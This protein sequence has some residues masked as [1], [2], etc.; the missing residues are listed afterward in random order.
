MRNRNKGRRLAIAGVLG[1]SIIAAPACSVHHG[2]GRSC[3]TYWYEDVGVALV[4]AA[5]FVLAA[6]S[7][8]HGHYHGHYGHG[9]YGSHGWGR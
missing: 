7:G 5:V 3:S 1:A 2:Y 9:Y 4:A 6:C 8:G